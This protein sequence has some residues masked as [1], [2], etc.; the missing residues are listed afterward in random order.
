MKKIITKDNS[1][2][3]RN[4]KYDETYHS[5]SGALEEAFEKFAKPCKLKDGVK[6]LDVCFGLGY[7]S[8]AAI[9]LADVEIIAL[10]ND[11]LILEKIQYNNIFN[12]EKNNYND[13]TIKNINLIKNYEKIKLATKNLFYKDNKVK[14]KIILEDARNT[15]KKLNEKFDVVFLDPFSP[16]NCPEL[17]TEEF[18]RDI[19]KVMK[20]RGVLATYSCAKVVR[21][22]LNNAGFKVKDGPCVGRKSPATLAY[23]K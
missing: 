1:I 19:W 17:W 6:I 16:K 15:I 22:N 3:F 5:T 10:E 23:K 20:K 14:I 18:F 13:K 4:E 9:S 7:N 11:S 12:N 2:T 8:L 21:S